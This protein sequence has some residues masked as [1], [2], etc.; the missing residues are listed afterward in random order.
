MPEI[1]ISY[2]TSEHTKQRE[3]LEVSQRGGGRGHIP[4]E[5]NISIITAILL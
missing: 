1:D 4:R 2:S 5:I 3:N